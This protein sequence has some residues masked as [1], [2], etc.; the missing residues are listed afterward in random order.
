MYVSLSRLT[1]EVRLE[2]LTYKLTYQ[3]RQ[4]LG[5]SLQGIGHRADAEGLERAQ[6][7]LVRHGAEIDLLEARDRRCPAGLLDFLQVGTGG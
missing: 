3:A 1:G 5:L 7:A 6:I 2:S 4:Q